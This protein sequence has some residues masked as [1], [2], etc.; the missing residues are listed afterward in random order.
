MFY[1]VATSVLVLMSIGLFVYYWRV[2]AFYKG[3]TEPVHAVTDQKEQKRKG[4]VALLPPGWKLLPLLFP[5]WGLRLVEGV[6]EEVCQLSE[7]RSQKIEE[8]RF[9][10]PIEPLLGGEYLLVSEQY[11]VTKGGLPMG[12]DMQVIRGNIE[13]EEKEET[14]TTRPRAKPRPKAKLTMRGNQVVLEHPRG[15]K[16]IITVVRSG[17][18]VE[19]VGPGKSLKLEAGDRVLKDV[20]EF[21]LIRLPEIV[22]KKDGSQRFPKDSSPREDK[23]N[24]T[25]RRSSKGYIID[26]RDG[27]DVG[28]Y[29][30]LALEERRLTSGSEIYLQRGDK[31]RVRD[32]IWVV[33]YKAPREKGKR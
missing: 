7:L 6:M 14:S 10:K 3:L 13:L 20:G 30:I 16:G 27:G 12:A 26:V 11:D 22:L 25:L 28:Y 21:R 24:V 15:G 23:G 18:E 31:F 32:R 19:V 4:V 17:G 5:F 2:Y 8:G 1:S 29:P 9:S 33:D